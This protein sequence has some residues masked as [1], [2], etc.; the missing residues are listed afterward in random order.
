M[1]K[2]YLRRIKTA[3]FIQGTILSE[4]AGPLNVRPDLE[5]SRQYPCFHRY[6]NT[7]FKTGRTL[8]PLRK[9]DRS[10]PAIYLLTSWGMSLEICPDCG[11]PWILDPFQ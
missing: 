8:L 7:P 11:L 2:R 10:N 9:N 3:G 1:R 5:P 6:H 4:N